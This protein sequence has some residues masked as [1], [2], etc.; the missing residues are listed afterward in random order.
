MGS[1]NISITDEAYKALAREKRKDESFTEVIIRLI[2]SN[3]KL[4]DCFG[5]WQMSDGEKE[6]IFDKEI[7]AGWKKS[8]DGLKPIDREIS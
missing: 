2:R 5:T 8:R 1:R 4:S 6:T 7:P 3:G